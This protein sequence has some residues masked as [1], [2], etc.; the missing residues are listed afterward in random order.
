MINIVDMKEF[1][2]ARR[3]AEL[4]WHQRVIV[5]DD[6]VMQ[7]G[8]DWEGDLRADLLETASDIVAQTPEETREQYGWVVAAAAEQAANPGQI[9]FSVR[10]PTEEEIAQHHSEL[11]AK[12]VQRLWNIGFQFGLDLPVLLKPEGVTR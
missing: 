1:R 5:L 8:G 3:N 7:W 4:L 11:V 2:L 6:A 12:A 10:Q 9:L